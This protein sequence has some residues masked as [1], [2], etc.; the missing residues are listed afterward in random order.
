MQRVRECMG[1]VMSAPPSKQAGGKRAAGEAGGDRQSRLRSIDDTTDDSRGCD[2]PRSRTAR[3]G[4]PRPPKG[5]PA[6]PRYP[7]DVTAADT[8]RA[9]VQF[10]FV[11]VSK[12]ALAPP[13]LARRVAT[14]KTHRFRH[15][16]GKRVRLADFAFRFCVRRRFD[17]KSDDT[18]MSSSRIF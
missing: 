15:F 5:A 2:P 9:Y 11:V 13:Q 1:D 17:S 12:A 6:F 4:L 14:R 8:P 7:S 10:A 18:I 3:P 16:S